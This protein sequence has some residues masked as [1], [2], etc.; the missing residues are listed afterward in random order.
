MNLLDL[1]REVGL[2][3]KHK[4]TCHGGEFSSP[5]PFCK[6]GNDRFLTWP[7]RHNRNGDYKGGRFTCRVCGRY[8]DAITFLRQFYNLSYCEACARLQI[9]PREISNNPLPTTA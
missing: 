1:V 4:A 9:E 7:Q 8:G 5:C 6:E 2:D 3:P